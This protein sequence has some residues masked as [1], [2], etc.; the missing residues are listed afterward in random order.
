MLDDDG[1]ITSS[2]AHTDTSRL[3]ADVANDGTLFYFF[4]NANDS[5]NYKVVTYNLAQP[6]KGF[7]DHIAHD[8]KKLLSSV[9]V[10]NDNSLLLLYSVD[11]KDEL[12]LHEL[13]SGKRVKRLAEDLI[14]SIEQIS[15]EREHKEFWFS[16]TSFVTP[17]TVYRYNFEAT[18]GQEQT[19]YRATKVAGIK[20]DDFVSEQVFYESKDGT[21]VPMFI[22]RPKDIKQDGT[23][24]AILYAYGGFSISLNPFFSPTFLTW[25]QHY[26]GVLAVPNLRG[27]GEY[28]ETWHVA[29]T[30]DK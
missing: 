30:K 26:K 18:E 3:T 25:I 28:G 13:Q 15:G 9:H 29:G 5:P 23:A 24:P 10:A 12:Y 2:S 20:A 21:R 11:V 16:I 6:E 17:G 27:G 14:G 1:E 8:P 22:T 19:V 7:Q 4:T